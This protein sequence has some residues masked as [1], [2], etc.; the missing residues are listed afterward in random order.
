MK[1]NQGDKQADADPVSL[2]RELRAAMDEGRWSWFM[3]LANAVRP[4][5]LPGLLI[6]AGIGETGGQYYHG[7]Y[8]PNEFTNSPW[9]RGGTGIVPPGSPPPYGI[10]QP[11]M[12]QMGPMGGQ[13]QMDPNLWLKQQE[14]ALHMAQYSGADP[15][16]VALAQ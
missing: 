14:L 7:W 15:M 4:R 6:K 10:T 5:L 12:G 2:R 8:L 13:P 9:R 3:K 16:R 11:G 1:Q